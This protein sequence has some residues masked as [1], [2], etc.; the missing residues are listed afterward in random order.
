MSIKLSLKYPHF[1]GW[2]HEGKTEFSVQTIRLRRK[3]QKLRK[4]RN[5]DEY[6]DFWKLVNEYSSFYKT[7]G[8]GFPKN[9]YN[10]L[11]QYLLNPD[12]ITT[13]SLTFITTCYLLK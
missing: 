13:I 4:T 8:Y 6:F 12:Q 5:N 9:K 3:A 1:K 7:R 10:S 11:F 2:R